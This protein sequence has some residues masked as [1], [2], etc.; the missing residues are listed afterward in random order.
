MAEP[1][2]VWCV[3]CIEEEDVERAQRTKSAQPVKI[4]QVDAVHIFST[5]EKARAFLETDYGRAHILYDYVLDM[6][7]RHESRAQ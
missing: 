5:E 4:L 6:P 1:Q 2:T 7:E 3:R